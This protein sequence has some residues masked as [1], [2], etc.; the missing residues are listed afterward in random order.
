[1]IVIDSDNYKASGVETFFF[2]GGEP[3]AR[4]P[5]F[6]EPVLLYLKART[7]NDVGIGACVWDALM[8]Q[9]NDNAG[10]QGHFP[11][12][13][14]PY[15]PGARQDRTDGQTPITK[16]L[17]AGLFAAN[18]GIH[19]F[20]LHSDLHAY[21]WRPRNWMPSD[22]NCKFEKE[23]DYIIAPDKGAIGRAEDFQR[24]YFPNSQLLYGEKVRDFATGKILKYDLYNGFDDR[25]DD[26]DTGTALVVDDIC[27]GGAT[28]NMLSATGA[29]SLRLDLWV[30]HGIFSKG[31][32]NLLENYGI[33]YTTD[34]F[35]R[36]NTQYF[37][38]HS[39]GRI[40][41]FSL[42]PIVKELCK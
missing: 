40:K 12:L 32:D 35:Y 5:V 8:R 10:G 9:Y 41:M 16:Q 28:F 34:S 33:I 13:F 21:N 6:T 30:S 4:I 29:M 7:W 38:L 3:H 18:R 1:M 27:D 15:M 19:V 31:F 14:M 36:G 17:V 37:D 42:D 22:L 24:A 2:P 11:T 39:P 23:Y 25:F 20:D 26:L